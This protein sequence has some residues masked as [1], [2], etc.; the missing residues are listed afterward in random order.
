MLIQQYGYSDDLARLLA[1]CGGTWFFLSSFIAVV[2]IDRFWGRRSLMIFGASGMTGSMIVLCIMAY[3]DIFAS[4]VV[5]AIF[6]YIFLF[7]FAVG[8][9]A[10]SWLY[11]VEVVP[12]RTRGPVNA[13]STA[14]NWAVNYTIVLVTPLLFHRIGWR[15][16]M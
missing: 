11:A 7:F 13:L 10:M 14:L 8:W 5:S 16:Y 6:L 12:L 1:A 9:S 3:V 15:T 2:G 4:Q